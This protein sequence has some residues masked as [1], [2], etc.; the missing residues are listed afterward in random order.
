MVLTSDT[1]DL[2]LKFIMSIYI[3]LPTFSTPL[4]ETPGVMLYMNLLRVLSLTS[5]IAAWLLTI[6]VKKLDSLKRFVRTTVAA[7][8]N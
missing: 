8:H 5:V 6:I 7:S 2:S 1:I 3:S 4:V